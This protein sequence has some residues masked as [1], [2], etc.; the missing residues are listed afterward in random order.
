MAKTCSYNVF[1]TIASIAA[2]EKRPLSYH[3]LNMSTGL[4]IVVIEPSQ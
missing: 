2:A 3:T 4:V 1:R